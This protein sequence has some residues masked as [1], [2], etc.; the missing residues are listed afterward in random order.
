MIIDVEIK[1]FHM[2]CG[3]GGGAAGFNRGEARLGDLR[4]KFRC[5]GG[6]DVDPAACRDFESKVGVPATC[7]DLF[8]REQYIAFHG[9][10]PSADWREA[11]PDDIRRAAGNEHPNIVF[12]SYPCKGFS[13]LLS[14][15]AS[16]TDKYQALNQL[17]VRGMWLVLEAFKDNPPEFIIFENVPRIATRG[18]PLVDRIKGLHFAYQYVGDEDTHDCGELGGLGQTRKRFLLV[19]RHAPKVP[20]F[21][22]QADRKPL[23]GV[24]EIIGDLP[25]PGPEPLLPMH[26]LPALHWKTWVRLA[27]VEAGK[28]WRSLNSLRVQ[29]GM[30]ADFGLAPDG[31]PHHGVLGV[32]PWEG[33]AAATVTGRSM[34][35]TGSHSVADPRAAGEYNADVLGVRRWGKHTGTVPGRSSPTNGAHSVADPRVDTGG[36][37]FHGMRV[38]AWVDTAGGITTQRSPGSSAQSVADPRVAGHERSVQMGVLPWQGRPAGVVTSKMFVGG[39]HHA[40]ADPRPHRVLFNHAYRVVRYGETAP[41][42]TG[43]GGAGGLAV[44]DPRADGGFHGKGK[45]RVAPMNGQAGTVI[46]GSTTG[47]GAFAIAD[48]RVDRQARRTTLGVAEWNEHSDSVRGESLPSNGTFAVSDPR[49]EFLQSGDREHYQTAGNYGVVP[50]E[51]HVGAIAAHGQHDNGRWSVADPRVASNEAAKSDDV[52]P[53]GN[54]SV[55]C[56]ILSLDNTWHRPFTT[57][58]LAALQGLVDPDEKLELDGLSDSA[59]RER[60]GNAVPPPA[61]AAIASVMGRALLGA[62]SGQTFMLSSEDIWVRPMVTAVMAAGPCPT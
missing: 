55:V 33:E 9:R 24:G 15:K 40:I 49:P 2:A 57:L 36:H 56:L 30:L 62:W 41:P 38:N 10:E 1:H 17:T 45:Y 32:R 37:D 51:D 5:L 59:W 43:P 50:W 8:S 18:R 19:F 13:G 7:I 23:R 52:L 6:I 22:Y 25:V 31:Y 4:A 28:D 26:R 12:A 14:E 35:Y 58:E 21:L 42:V 48:P 44:A 39:G 34:P 11:T 61:A 3:L 46:G 20:N 60:I 54:E 16:R 53:G 29:D 27:F 47:Q